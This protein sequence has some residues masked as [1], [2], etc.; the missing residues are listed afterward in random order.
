MRCWRK[1][2]TRSLVH[3]EAR[4]GGPQ[5]LARGC[6]VAARRETRGSDQGQQARLEVG[7]LVRTPPD[8]VL[9][10]TLLCR[11]IRGQSLLLPWKMMVGS[12]VRCP[13]DW[14]RPP[15][16]PQRHPFLP[17]DQSFQFQVLCGTG[18]GTTSGG[19]H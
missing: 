8:R 11:G 2:Q 9:C 10:S 13:R 5:R 12:R 14:P 18:T 15:G 1:Q 4:H 17:G 6:P 3:W 19:R 7:E 16:T